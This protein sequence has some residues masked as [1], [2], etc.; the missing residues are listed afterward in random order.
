LQ[1]NFKAYI[2]KN[3]K[4]YIE[5]IN[6]TNKKEISTNR[7]KKYQTHNIKNLDKKEFQCSR[8]RKGKKR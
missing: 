1:K 3:F 8:K 5:H 4:A 6:G 2:E 7:G